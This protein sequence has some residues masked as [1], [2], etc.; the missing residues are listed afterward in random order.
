MGDDIDAKGMGSGGNDDVFGNILVGGG[1][2]LG[3][4]GMGSDRGRGGLKTSGG[5][6]LHDALGAWGGSVIWCITGNHLG[7]VQNTRGKR[8]ALGDDG[9]VL[10]GVLS[11]TRQQLG[12]VN[13]LWAHGSSTL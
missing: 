4:G 13:Q 5:G 12:H 1:V 6:V 3:T 2:G 10:G 7:G 9:G 8:T 11:L